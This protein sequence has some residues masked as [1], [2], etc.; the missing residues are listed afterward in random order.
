MRSKRTGCLVSIPPPTQQFCHRLIQLHYLPWYPVTFWSY[1]AEIC[2]SSTFGLSSVLEVTVTLSV[3][4]TR[5]QPSISLK[6]VS[7]QGETPLRPS[8][9]PPLPC[10]ISAPKTMLPWLGF[11]SW[12]L[13]LICF[14]QECW[15]NVQMSQP[16]FHF[17]L[18][19]S[20]YIATC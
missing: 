17:W 5:H 13:T 3:P 10:S 7:L 4:P 15:Y 14:F 16:G 2:L 1:W 6:P 18:W 11:I 8:W 9:F 20:F 12:C 19:T